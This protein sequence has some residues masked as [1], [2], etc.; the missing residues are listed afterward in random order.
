MDQDQNLLD[1]VIKSYKLATYPDGLLKDASY[2]IKLL[3]ND[4]I[5][6]Y[7]IDYLELSLQTHYPDSKDDL[8]H[9]QQSLFIITLLSYDSIILF[10]L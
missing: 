6:K 3:A 10:N 5:L 8:E 9:K 2:I 7:I 4:S 1:L